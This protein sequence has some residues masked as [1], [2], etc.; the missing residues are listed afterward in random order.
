MDLPDTNNAS[1]QTSA[2]RSRRSSSLLDA[3][4]TRREILLFG[5]LILGLVWITLGQEPRTLVI[6]PDSHIRVGVIT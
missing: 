2:A 1:P 5:L 4:A 6:V 3:P